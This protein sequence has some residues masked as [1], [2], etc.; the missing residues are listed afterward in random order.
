L[1]FRAEE[2]KRNCAGRGVAPTPPV[3]REGVEGT[4]AGKEKP[5]PGVRP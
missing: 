1:L 4:L 5:G 2:E 3:A